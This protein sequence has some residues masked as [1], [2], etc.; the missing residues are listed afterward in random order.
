M[1]IPPVFC[2]FKHNGQTLVDGGF[3]DNFPMALFPSEMTVGFRTQWNIGFSLDGF[4]QYFGRL[5]Y[6]A[7]AASEAAMWEKLPDDTKAR[8]ITIPTGDVTT[9][10]LRLTESEKEQIVR[11]GAAAKL[12]A[13]FSNI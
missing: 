2:P 8:I 12:D 1:A 11:T 4:E 5:C 13:V 9:I 6:C 10:D 7:M 3:V